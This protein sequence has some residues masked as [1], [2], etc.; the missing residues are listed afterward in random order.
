MA[1]DLMELCLQHKNL[2]AIDKYY[3]ASVVS[4]ESSGSPEMPAEMKGIESVRQ[5]NK[6]WLENNEI[7][8]AKVEGPYVGPDGFALAFE[9]E[10][11]N[12]P[13]KKRFSLKEIGL[14][15]V[16]DGKII[17]EHFFYNPGS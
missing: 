6:W 9:Y 16:A 8:Q 2:E 13:S 1:K 14:Y 12:K 3:D 11:T 10:F 15:K 7:H 4:V 17:H 5:K